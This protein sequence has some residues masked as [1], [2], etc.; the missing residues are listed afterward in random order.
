V[1]ID[2]GSE[3][4]NASHRQGLPGRHF[5]PP[6]AAVRGQARRATRA[7]DLLPWES[8]GRWGR[9]LVAIHAG[10][11]GIGPCRRPV[12]WLDGERHKPSN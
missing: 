3:R 10:R 9:H 11:W 7:T 5:R 8:C 2:Q 1:S 12:G 4:R 6:I